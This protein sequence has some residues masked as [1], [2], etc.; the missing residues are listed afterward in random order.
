MY[1]PEDAGDKS[2]TWSSSN[3]SVAT[4]NPSTGEVTA[5][6]EGT[7][8]ITATANDDSGTTATCTVK[9]YPA[10][11]VVW[12]PSNWGNQYYDDYSPCTIDGMTLTMSG[13]AKFRTGPAYAELQ[14]SDPD[15]GNYTFTAPAGKK[16]TKIEINGNDNSGWEYNNPMTSNGWAITGGYMTNYKATWTGNANTVKL[17]DSDSHFGFMPEVYSILFLVQ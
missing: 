17:F 14:C 13:Y 3:T 10:G 1:L 9:V 15:T 16:F 7:A 2:V 6:A 12:D 8:T 5:V 11:T 4:V